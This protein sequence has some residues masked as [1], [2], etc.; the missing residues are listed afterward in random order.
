MS[1]FHKLKKSLGWELR[2]SKPEYDLNPLIYQQLKPFRV[3]LV[4]VQLLMMIGTVGYVLID[5]FPILDAIYQTGITFTT[6]GFGEVAPISDAGRFFT[7]TLIIIGFA[8]FTLSIAVLIEA[9]IK[10]N[11]IELYKERNMLYKIAR[12][13]RHFVIFHH[14]EYTIQLARQFRENHVPFVVVDPRE[15]MEEIANE[16]HYPYY[17]CEESF[18]EKAFLKSHLSSAKG[19]ITLSRNISDNITLIASV[20]LYE[21]ELGRNKPFLIISNAETQHDKERLKKLG[22]DKVVASPSLMAKRVSAMAV[23]PDMENVL[24]EFLYKPDT[25]IDMEEVLVKEDSWLVSRQLKDIHLRDRYKVSVIGITEKR[26]RFIQMPK[27]T[28]IIEGNC[29]L[30]LVGNQ[31]GIAKAKILVNQKYMPEECTK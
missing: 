3:P 20:R 19:V 7:V 27:G 26:G 11:L 10:G 18:T 25:P 22:A 4:L 12:L 21:K 8:L 14:N 30:L 28:I 16:Y 5:G 6:V 23:R 29:K 15:D 9:I 2:S 24:E 31:K 1:I 17:V 13:R